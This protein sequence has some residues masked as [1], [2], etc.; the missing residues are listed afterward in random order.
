MKSNP[1]K[2][3]YRTLCNSLEIMGF[4]VVRDHQYVGHIARLPKGVTGEF[5]LY[6]G[7]SGSLWWVIRYKENGITENI[8]SDRHYL[9]SDFSPLL[10]DISKYLSNA[11]FYT[12]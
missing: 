11:P 4:K 8:D 1:D 3:I 2:K 5:Q 6:F 9:P 7:L 10:E 12:R